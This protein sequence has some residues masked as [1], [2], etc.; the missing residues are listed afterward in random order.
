MNLLWLD[1][2]DTHSLTLIIESKFKYL[3]VGF[4]KAKSIIGNLTGFTFLNYWAR[5]S[6]NLIIG[7]VFGA[8]SLGIYNR[9]YR[10][11]NMILQIITGLFGKVLY[12]SLKDFM[13][14]GGNV[15]K[16]SKLKKIKFVGGLEPKSQEYLYQMM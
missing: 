16:K 8:G 11:L 14:K 6:D 7:K 10:M 9:A 5:N 4:R 2:R 13:N 3:V 15:N 1:N 12:P